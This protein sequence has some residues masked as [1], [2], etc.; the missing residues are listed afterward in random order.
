V[1]TTL[2]PP[3]P[4]GLKGPARITGGAGGLGVAIGAALAREGLRRIAVLS[5]ERREPG[6]PWAAP[7]R[8][9]GAEVLV[10]R[11]DVTD[12]AALRAARAQIE[13]AWGPVRVVIHAAGLAAQPER[14]LDRPRDEMARLMA[15]KVQGARNLHAVFPVGLDRLVLMSSLSASEP[16][17]ARGMSDY[18]VANAFLDGLAALRAAEGEAAMSIAWPNWAEVGMGASAVAALARQGQG[19]LTVAQGTGLLLR[20]L[21]RPLPHLIVPAARA[22]TPP[23]PTPRPSSAAAP[24]A[25]RAA[26]A[27]AEVL[28]EQLS[29]ALSV[30]AA[31]IDT[32]ARFMDLGVDSLTLLGFARELERRFG[33]TLYPSVYFEHPSV[34]ALS[35]H[36]EAEHGGGRAPAAPSAPTTRALRFRRWHFHD[37]PI[38]ML[39]RLTGPCAPEALRDA[40]ATLQARHPL[41]QADAVLDGDELVLQLGRPPE[42]AWLERDLR[43]A[44]DEERSAWIQ[45]QVARLRARGGPTGLR[46]RLARLGEQDQALI[47]GIS[48]RVCDGMS[49]LVLQAELAAALRGEA[50]PPML[51]D[52][53]QALSAAD[54]LAASPQQA[55]AD[56][57]WRAALEPALPRLPTDHPRAP[58]RALITDRHRVVLDAA[59]TAALWAEARRRGVTAYAL[60]LGLLSA[61]L[62][63]WT[64][65]ESAL[66]G[67][68]TAGRSLP[69]PGVERIFG[70]LVRVLPLR[71]TPG[72]TLTS[73][74][75]DASAAVGGALRF[76]H[77]PPRTPYV[78]SISFT[79]PYDPS[80]GAAAPA[81]GAVQVQAEEV[82][83]ELGEEDL[84][85]LL[86]GTVAPTPGGPAL[87]LDWTWQPSL[88]EAQTVRTL[89]EAWRAGLKT[90][91]EGG[92]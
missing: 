64:G 24:A 68:P 7:L 80:M 63:R 36:L 41:L 19:S 30:P 1:P 46:A 86:M 57:C 61:A 88:Y 84:D 22:S 74:L 65:A 26:G 82:W 53:A 32:S 12:E 83:N 20:A 90:L 72:P 67:M 40:L 52:L 23:P 42:D 17:L 16:N 21:T 73:A 2:P 29:R 13:A 69:V 34:D 60:A 43:A 15:A 75:Q 3:G 44:S 37:N 39:L 78:P 71:L 9:E 33:I 81:E 11:A 54:T 92:E 55:E 4:L 14:L 77:L 79:F 85:L 45:G 6:E 31:Q 10:I 89:A 51:G 70:P 28:I 47:L 38:T 18:A 66:V 48:H 8:R 56:A 25:P 62:R 50:L 59:E 35:A 27:Y 76:A 49:L 58:G 87:V 5:R 91:L